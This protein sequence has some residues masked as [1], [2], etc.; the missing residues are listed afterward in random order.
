MLMIAILIV[1]QIGKLSFLFQQCLSGGFEQYHIWRYY[2]ITRQPVWKQIMP[3]EWREDRG[4]AGHWQGVG[5]RSGGDL[6]VTT[7]VLQSS[8]ATGHCS[9]SMF[10]D[11][12]S[13]AFWTHKEGK[14]GSNEHVCKFALPDLKYLM[15]FHAVI[16]FS[17]L[18]TPIKCHS[19]S[20]NSLTATWQSEC[21]YSPVWLLFKFSSLWRLHPAEAEGQCGGQD[22]LQFG[23]I[24]PPP[25]LPSPSLPP[26][27]LPLPS[28]L[29]VAYSRLMLIWLLIFIERPNLAFL[30]PW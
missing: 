13:H 21:T 27:L 20:L 2:T 14:N 17:L 28:P 23:N 4:E 5:G 8:R 16:F 12:P 25:S 30:I 22:R 3:P 29:M 15:E 11:P 26:S 7:G 19:V 10:D 18:W 1:V 9:C 24:S 6:S